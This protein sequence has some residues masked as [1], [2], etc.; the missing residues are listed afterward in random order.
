MR[1]RLLLIEDDDALRELLS[2]HLS[3]ANFE[4]IEAATAGDAWAHIAE[5]SIIVL[6]W[7]LPDES[8]IDWLKRFRQADKG[9]LPVL[10]LTARASE[11][12]KV[13]G[14]NAGADDYLA[15]PFSSAELVARLNALLR[16]TKTVQRSVIGDLLID[17]EQGVA[18]FKNSRL[19]LTRR[20]FDLLSFLALHPGRVFG[21]MEL[22]DR[23]W[24][25]DFL[26]TDRTV[27][28]HVAQLRALIGSEYIETVR[29][30]GYRLVDPKAM[31]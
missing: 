21:R 30:R 27:D 18:Q 14:L 11:M 4:V 31:S 28:Q 3:K 6:D 22:L 23:V 7:M 9:D 26:G 17:L 15:K 25:E 16:R 8:G 29:G 10:M 19:E 20:E 5:V 1:T 13:T 12:D 2:F 24:G